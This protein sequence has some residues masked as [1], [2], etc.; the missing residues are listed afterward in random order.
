MIGKEVYG[1]VNGK[2]DTSSKD[3]I[4][5]IPWIVMG[6]CSFISRDDDND[7]D[8][9]HCY[10]EEDPKH[11]SKYKRCHRISL[12]FIHLIVSCQSQAGKN[13]GWHRTQGR[14]RKRDDQ[15]NDCKN[16]RAD[17]QTVRWSLLE[18]RLVVHHNNIVSRRWL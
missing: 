2:L 14:S 6:L 16:E 18:R 10:D 7:Y 13:N 3:R 15:G 9:D 12:G 4:I 17:G 1:H 8:D 11:N 5:R